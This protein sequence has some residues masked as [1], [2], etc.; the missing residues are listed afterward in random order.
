[1]KLNRNVGQHDCVVSF[2][3]GRVISL[4]LVKYFTENID[5]RIAPNEISHETWQKCLP[6]RVSLVNSFSSD[7]TELLSLT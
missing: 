3:N 7:R 4:D 5:Y 1:M 6:P 2:S